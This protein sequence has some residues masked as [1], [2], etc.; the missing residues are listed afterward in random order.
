MEVPVDWSRDDAAFLVMDRFGTARP[1]A[2]A[3]RP[4]R[5]VARRVPGARAAGGLFQLTMHPDLIGRR[6]RM[7][8]LEALL[9]RIAADGDAWVATHAEVAAWCLAG[10]APGGGT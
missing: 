8:V 6:S 2:G 9:E 10:A 3:T 7:V 4:A 1:D 5:R